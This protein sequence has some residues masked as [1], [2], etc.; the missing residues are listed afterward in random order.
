MDTPREENCDAGWLAT[1]CNM[2]AVPG[3][4]GEMEQNRRSSRKQAK[5]E[6]YG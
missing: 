3:V 5:Q 2:A 1:N 6:P 4:P